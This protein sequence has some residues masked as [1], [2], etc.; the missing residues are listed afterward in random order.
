MGKRQLGSKIRSSCQDQSRV[1]F[2][3]G[4]NPEE[5]SQDGGSASS[6]GPKVFSPLTFGAKTLNLFVIE[7]F[8]GCARLS[9]ACASYGFT[10][11]AFDIEY[12]DGCDVLQDKV[13]KKL[14][15]FIWKHRKKIALIWLGTPCTSWFPVRRHDGGPPP[16]RDNHDCLITGVPHLNFHDHQ[17]VLLGNRLLDRSVEIIDLAMLCSI[18]FVA[19]AE[20]HW[21]TV[22]AF[23]C[24]SPSISHLP[25]IQ[26]SMCF[27]WTSPREFDRQRQ[28]RHLVHEESTAIP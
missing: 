25:V 3:E 7:I 9:R 6:S 8:S 15:R 14:R 23:S 20:I 16:L 24:N 11:F 27:L 18:L 5:A 2:A 1:S 17:K 22:L 28:P 19:L 12:N 4:T 26:Q 10:A 21:C 13:W